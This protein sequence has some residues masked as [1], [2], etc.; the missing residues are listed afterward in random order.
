MGNSAALDPYLLNTVKPTK[1]RCYSH[2]G[3]CHP[4]GKGATRLHARGVSFCTV[5]RLRRD[6]HA[7]G[8]AKVGRPAVKIALVS[9][10]SLY[11]TELYARFFASH[12][13]DV[14]VISLSHEP[15]LDGIAVDVVGHG[16][17]TRLK[18]FAYLRR[19]P[20]V[21]RQLRRFGPDVVMATY[22]SSNGLIAALCGASPLLVSAHGSDVLTSPGG[23][24]LHGRMMRFA[25]RSADIVHAVSPAIADALVDSGAARKSIRCFPIGIDTEQ[26]R[27][28]PEPG[29]DHGLPRLVCTRNQAPVYGNATIILALKELRDQDGIALRAVLLGGGPLLAERRAQVAELGLDD[30]VEL[31]GRV[32]LDNVRRALQEA[33][34]YVSAS[35]SDG[36]SSSLLEAMACGLFPVVSDIPGNRDWIDDGSTGLLFA[37][38]DAHGLAAALRRAVSDD[39]LRAT[40]RERNRARVIADGNLATNMAVMEQLLVELAPRRPQVP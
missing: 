19:V 33:D 25:C 37:V 21:R 32:P 39:A 7:S 13:H 26:F 30:L 6:G 38:G 15:S 12:G 18:V 10:T 1:N 17:P 11:W 3:G 22:V 20:G 8:A 23:A 9:H 28:Q 16:T 29:A 2:A 35:S 34:I 24:W 31:P 5:D 40:A 27:P 4:R 14:R 36:A